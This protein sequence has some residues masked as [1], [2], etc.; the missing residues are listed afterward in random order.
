MKLL[1]QHR[2]R[3]DISPNG[4][5]RYLNWTASSILEAQSRSLYRDSVL[6]VTSFPVNTGC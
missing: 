3:T 2:G 6:S 4:S 1:L 5:L